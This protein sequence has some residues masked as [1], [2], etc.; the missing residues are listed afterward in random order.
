MRVLVCGGR[1]Y[2]SKA[3][4]FAVLDLIHARIAISCLIQGGASGADDLARL[5][6]RERGVPG[7]EYRA[8][9]VSTASAPA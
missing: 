8:E 5:W 3:R 2:A 4:V 9:W 1:T 6:A 7:E